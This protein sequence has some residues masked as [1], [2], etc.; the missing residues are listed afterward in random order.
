MPKVNVIVS[1][2]NR[3]Q[4]LK[5]AIESLLA[6]DFTDWQAVVVDDGSDD[7]GVREFLSSTS[8][9][10]SRVI[11]VYLEHSGS[12]INNRNAGIGLSS[13]SEFITFLDDD[14]VY[15]PVRLS[16]MLRKMEDPKAKLDMLATP[17]KLIDSSGV[18]H[19]SLY[20]PNWPGKF[21]PMRLF[22]QNYI[23]LGAVMLRTKA[24]QDVGQ[25]DPFVRRL[26]DWDMWLR[27]MIARKHIG[28]INQVLQR[29]RIHDTT[30]SDHEHGSDKDNL[31]VDM[32]FA[33][34][35]IWNTYNPGYMGFPPWPSVLTDEDEVKIRERR[36]S[37]V[38]R[39]V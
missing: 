26:E 17:S 12:P 4:Y 38:H 36:K 22:A 27:F 14:N 21:D 11:P 6:Q 28:V 7:P 16:A 20:P 31:D 8:S 25:F 9:H 15:E 29:Y 30:R 19:K 3:P 18:V 33:N 39:I 32:K 35:V 5:E 10:D 1:S 13:L 34:E 23:D 37:Y 24:L 2:Y